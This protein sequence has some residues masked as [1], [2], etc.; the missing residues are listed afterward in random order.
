MLLTNFINVAVNLIGLAAIG[1]KYYIV[2]V[3]CLHVEAVAIYCLLVE[4]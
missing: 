2:Y 3:G 1:W 4:T